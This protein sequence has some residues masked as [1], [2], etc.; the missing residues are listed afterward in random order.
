MENTY[1]IYSKKLNKLFDSVDEAKEAELQFDNELKAKKAKQELAT[2]ERKKLADEIEIARKALNEAE[3]V[4]KTKVNDFIKKYGYYH[5]SYSKPLS[6]RQFND[7]FDT[8][9][10]MW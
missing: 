5:T 1:Q 10:R 9:F 4:Y 7:I 2:T 6:I 8:F 3:Q